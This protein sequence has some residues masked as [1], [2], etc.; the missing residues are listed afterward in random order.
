LQPCGTSA[1]SDARGEFIFTGIA[2]GSYRLG[3]TY[4][5]FSPFSTTV[6]AVS[7]QMTRADIELIIDQ[8]TE[9]ILVRANGAHREVEAIRQQRNADNIVQVMSS[10]T[11]NSLPNANVGDAIGRLPSITLD[12][13]AGEARYVQI[14][15]P[16]LASTM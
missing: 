3:T 12:S 7:G 1:V 4:T 10:E 11:I 13:D 5:G 2:Q 14:R 8:R 15:A 9:S 6:I 16:S